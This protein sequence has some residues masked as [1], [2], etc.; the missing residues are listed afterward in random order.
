MQLSLSVR[1]AEEFHSKE[2]AS[3]PLGDLAR[4]AKRCGYG[5]LCM[6]ASQV[7][8]QSHSEAIEAAVGCLAEN[9]L[10]VSMVTGDFDTVYNNDNGPSALQNITPYLDLAKRLGAPRIRV[11]LKQ[12]SDIA[13]AQRAA[14]EAAERGIQLVHQCHTMSLFETVDNIEQTLNAIDRPN[15]G[16][17]YEPANLE[18]CGQDYGPATIERLAKWVFNVYLQNQLLKPDGAVTLPTWCAGDVSFDLIS[19]HA[20]GGVDFG[21]VLAG[22]KAI[23]YDG[24]LTVHQSAQPGETPESSAAG[25][26][27]FLRALI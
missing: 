10:D 13:H 27:D 16:L 9:G 23:D 14:D 22:L 5:A 3:M 20:P 1:I 15:F 7:G 21:H 17:V 18:I 4:L 26:A 8:V 19:V 12:E 6:R 25:T 2:E 24:T 11:A